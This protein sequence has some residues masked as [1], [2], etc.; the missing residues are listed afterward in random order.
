MSYYRF[1]IKYLGIQGRRHVIA[2]ALK[3]AA[4]KVSGIGF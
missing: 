3:L 2:T 1:L 4:L